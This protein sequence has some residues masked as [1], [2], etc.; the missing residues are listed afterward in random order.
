MVKQKIG[1]RFMAAVRRSSNQSDAVLA[2]GSAALQQELGDLKL[3]GIDRVHQRGDLADVAGGI[4]SIGE[5]GGQIQQFPNGLKIADAS[6]G[7]N[8]VLSAMLDKQ[9][10]DGVAAGG[11]R[12]TERGHGQHGQAIGLRIVPW[13]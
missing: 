12:A 3:F 4:T 7:E 13:R 8:V 6:G 5:F 11:K 2:H 9:L 10:N 1:Q